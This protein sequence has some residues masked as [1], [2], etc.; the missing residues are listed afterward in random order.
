[1]EPTH[2]TIIVSIV[3]F[4][5][6]AAIVIAIN[7]SSTSTKGAPVSKS[8]H[9]VFAPAMPTPTV[10][11]SE[12]SDAC[13]LGCQNNPEID[14]VNNPA[15][16]M[17]EVIENALLLEQHLA[18][19]RKYCK[20]CCVKHFLL[21]HGLLEE[22]I[23]MACKDCKKYPKLQESEAFFKGLFETW[24]AQMESDDMRLDTLEK[25]RKWRQEA[26]RLYFFAK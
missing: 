12:G 6:L 17:Q 5:L 20:E 19:K 13:S 3:I 1:M 9:D 4:F 22:A 15:Y 14:D 2:I 21:I 10:S 8:Y 24:K 16:N 25:L 26:I 23:W 11:G 18:E 7:K